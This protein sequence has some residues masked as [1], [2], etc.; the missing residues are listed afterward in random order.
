VIEFAWLGRLP[1]AVFRKRVVNGRQVYSHLFNIPIVMQL[2][3]WW[4]L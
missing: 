4:Y 2:A 3:E 1:V